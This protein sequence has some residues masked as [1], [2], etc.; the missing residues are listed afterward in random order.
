MMR[1]GRFYA[2]AILS[3]ILGAMATQGKLGDATGAT[4]SGVAEIVQ[5]VAIIF[6]TRPGQVPG[7]PFF[8]FD[9]FAVVD[10]PVTELPARFV[11]EAKRALVL[12]E[13]RA[14]LV[15]ARVTLDAQQRP[16]GTIVFQ[17]VLGAQ[18]SVEVSL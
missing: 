7:R 13:P 15:S 16:R 9:A 12:N 3:L 8:G 11:R 5:S 10:G 18:Q 2:A 4:L 6:G 17:P 1:P 14:K